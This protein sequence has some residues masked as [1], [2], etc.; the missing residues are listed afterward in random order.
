MP[1]LR[2]GN[3]THPYDWA[4]VSCSWKYKYDI[5]SLKIALISIRKNRSIVGADGV[6]RGKS[7][8][9]G[10]DWGRVLGTGRALRIVW[11]TK[12]AVFGRNV[13]DFRRNLIVFGSVES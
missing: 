2:E 3:Q 8:V 7:C 10:E 4:V 9:F 11:G 13:V 12:G 6:V 5:N 1:Q